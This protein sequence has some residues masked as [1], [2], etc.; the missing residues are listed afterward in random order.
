MGVFVCISLEVIFRV[1][2]CE[3]AYN[4]PRHVQHI[5]QHGTP[6][7]LSTEEPAEHAASH[8]SS[9]ITSNR[10]NIFSAI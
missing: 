5:L 6:Q 4:P 7:D 3:Q 8:K 1:S 2:E 9:L 10:A